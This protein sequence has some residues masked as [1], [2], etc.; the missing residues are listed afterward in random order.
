MHFLFRCSFL[1]LRQLPSRFS[2]LWH[3]F[4][5]CCKISKVSWFLTLTLYLSS[6][7]P[8]SLISFN[9]EWPNIMTSFLLT[10]LEFLRGDCLDDVLDNVS[11]HDAFWFCLLFD[12]GLSDLLWLFKKDDWHCDVRWLF[13]VSPLFNLIG[14][15]GIDEI[16]L[17]LDSSKNIEV[18]LLATSFWSRCKQKS[19]L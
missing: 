6:D 16:D 2:F 18:S 19:I 8:S 4:Y 13:L 5:F 14:S 9:I 11:D 1:K 12:Y 10:I 17:C 3:L 7:R 15:F